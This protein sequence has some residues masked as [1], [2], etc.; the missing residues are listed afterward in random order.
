MRGIMVGFSAL[1]FLVAVACRE[2]AD[3]EGTV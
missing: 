3:I 1:F 2:S